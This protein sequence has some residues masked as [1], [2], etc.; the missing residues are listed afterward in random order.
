MNAAQL[1]LL[2]KRDLDAQAIDWCSRIVAA[3]GSI[4]WPTLYAASRFVRSC[5]AAGIWTKLN[6]V[7]LLCGNQLTAALVPLKVGGGSA[8]ETNVNF[9]SGD[10]TEATGIT[11]NGTSKYL[12]TGFNPV[13]AGSSTSSFGMF[14]Y[15]SGTDSAG[16][17]RILIGNQSSGTNLSFVG[18]AS[19]GTVEVGCIGATSSA[20]YAPSGAS[21][22]KQGLLGIVANGS[23]SQQYYQNGAAVGSAVVASGS[24]FNGNIFVGATNSSGSPAAY[25]VRPLRGYFITTGMSAAEV[26]ALNTI[27]ERFQDDLLR[28]VQ[29]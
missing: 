1:L 18:W 17:S 5:K 28:G 15:A 29:S 7:N 23:R 12:N 13:T 26:A 25:A 27:M 14:M 3:G 10:Y 21:A 19:S 24:F 4:S 2:R 9:V 16:T 20:E 22:A 6:R 11:G 8:T